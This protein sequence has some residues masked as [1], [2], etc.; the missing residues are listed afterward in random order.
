MLQFCATHFPTS[1]HLPTSLSPETP[2]GQRL[3]MAD[4]SGAGLMARQPVALR[5]PPPHAVSGLQW[6]QPPNRSPHASPPMTSVLAPWA[7]AVSVHRVLKGPEGLEGPK[8]CSGVAITTPTPRASGTGHM[9]ALL[10][11]LRLPTLRAP[12]PPSRKQKQGLRSPH[13]LLSHHTHNITCVALHGRTS[14]PVRNLPC[15]RF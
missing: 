15:G 13:I 8:K 7:S 12:P 2:H 6:Q 9:G 11:A 5:G 10:H 4:G 3:G 14:T 1:L